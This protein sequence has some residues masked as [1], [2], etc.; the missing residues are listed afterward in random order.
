MILGLMKQF[1]KALGRSGDCFDYIRS[2]FPGLSYENKKSGVFDG[3]QIKTLLKYHH[4]VIA[5]TTVEAQ[6][7]N[8]FADVIHNFLGNNKADNYREIVEKLL[9]S[10]QELRS[11]M[12]IELHYTSIAA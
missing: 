10:L 3:P 2:T 6:A 8:A 7:W 12:S 5:M 4:F 11:R 9:L 1:V